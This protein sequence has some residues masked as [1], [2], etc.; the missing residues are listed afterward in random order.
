MRDF[1]F[2][3]LRPS[4]W[5]MQVLEGYGRAGSA[6]EWLLNLQEFTQLTKFWEE[7]FHRAEAR[8]HDIIITGTNCLGY[9]S[10]TGPFASDWQGCQAGV[11]GLGI[12]SN[13]NIRGCLSLK[14]D[15]FIEGSL[16]EQSLVE[17]WH[18][19]NSFRYNREF[20]DM[21]LQGYCKDCEWGPQCRGGC[22]SMAHSIL[23]NPWEQP[24]CSW[25]ESLH[26]LNDDH[27]AIQRPMPEDRPSHDERWSNPADDVVRL[28]RQNRQLEAERIGGQKEKEERIYDFFSLKAKARA[29]RVQPE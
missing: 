4:G 12:D 6:R 7:T 23:G 29:A 13:G 8:G 21:D 15:S 10:S 19:K 9:Y 11:S 16:K 20:T 18:R 1:I 24:Y 14:H 25:L 27:E 17:L 22:T 3:E 5:Q 28:R 2:N 26:R